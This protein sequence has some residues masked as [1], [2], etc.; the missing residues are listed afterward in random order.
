[1]DRLHLSNKEF[2]KEVSNENTDLINTEEIFCNDT[3]TNVMH[4]EILKF[5]IQIIIICP[6]KVELVIDKIFQIG[7]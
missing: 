3:K 7:K 6:L 4:Q 1:M 5:T 2:L